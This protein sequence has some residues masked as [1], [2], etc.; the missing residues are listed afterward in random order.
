MAI[1]AVAGLGMLAF[2]EFQLTRIQALGS[3]MRESPSRPTVGCAG[4]D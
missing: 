4:A 3:R 2:N 1:V